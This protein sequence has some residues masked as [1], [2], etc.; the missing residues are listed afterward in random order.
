MKL[1]KLSV[2]VKVGA[3]ALAV[4]LASVAAQLAYFPQKQIDEAIVGLERK[5]ASIATLLAYGA[6]PALEFEDTKGLED[7]L[8]GGAEDVD[9]VFA[10]AFDDKGTLVARQGTVP[11]DVR[12]AGAAKTSSMVGGQLVV[13]TPIRVRSGAH[14]ALVAGFSLREI[15]RARESA[16]R[17]TALLGIIILALGLSVAFLIGRSLGRRLERLTE[18]GDRVAS[19]DLSRAPTEDGSSDEIGQLA[20]SF[21]AMHAILVQL[22]AHVMAVA[23]GDLSGRVDVAGDLAVALNTMTRVQRE[24][25]EQIADTSV[26]LSSVADE[27]LQN[28]RHQEMGATE[29]S[30]ALDQTKKSMAA[31]LA[32]GRDI[33]DAASTVLES[34][35]RAQRNSRTVT[36]RIGGLSGETRRIGEIVEIIKDIAN[37]SELLALNAALEGAK[38]GEAGRGFMLVATQMQRL[39]ENVKGAVTDIK[40]LTVAI[41]VSTQATVLAADES[42]KIASAHTD[43]ARQIAAIIRG[44]QVATEQVSRATD[45]AAAVT[46]ASVVGSREVVSSATELRAQADELRV[47][48]GRFRQVPQAASGQAAWPPLTPAPRGEPTEQ[49]PERE[50]S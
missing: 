4:V 24:L 46:A 16:I 29:Q 18:V 26:K 17:A 22:E 3:A 43:A 35:E 49:V 1:L 20:R 39:A 2:G 11:P 19:G 30:S 25:T 5:A 31:L 10:A 28:A 32:S 34:A 41:G 45:S 14:G 44:Q 21:Q 37:K 47:R 40:N 38:A 42:A 50:L 27:L 33:G 12:P 7:V 9:F 15:E 23:D 48:V 36:E 6:A 8:A 13:T